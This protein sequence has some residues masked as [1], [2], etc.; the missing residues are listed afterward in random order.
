M[1][2]DTAANK[3]LA[4]DTTD[5][6]IVGFSTSTRDEAKKFIGQ[7]NTQFWGMNSLWQFLPDIPWDAWFEIH[8]YNHLEEIHKQNWP[9]VRKH[10]Q[11]LTIPLWMIDQDEDFPTS[12]TFPIDDIVQELGYRKYFES[13]VAYVLAF[14]LF[15]H[16]CGNKA[17][18]ALERVHLYGID[19]IHDTEWG[20]QRPNAEYWCGLLEGN[21]VKVIQHKD[22]ALLSS[23][24]LYG[25][26]EEPH[27][28]AEMAGL[29]KRMA[30]RQQELQN[31]ADLHNQKADVELLK[32]AA[33]E[34]AASEMENMKTLLVQWARNRKL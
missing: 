24:W 14:A 11:D 4:K 2:L 17:V 6:V 3:S 16:L 1:D 21:S 18:T 7:P 12:Q 30:A 15:L 22:S 13:T 26:E 19:M 29:L 32:K 23:Q 27:K 20:Y 33:H 9:K 5:L 28:T 25:Y 31:I 34:G 8:R 10:Y